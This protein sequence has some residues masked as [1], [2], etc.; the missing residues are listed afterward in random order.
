MRIVLSCLRVSHRCL[1]RRCWQPVVSRL[2]VWSLC[3]QIC[4]RL[5]LWA[6]L[7][8]RAQ[9]PCQPVCCRW[10]WVIPPVRPRCWQVRLLW[11]WRVWLWAAAAAGIAPNHRPRVAGRPV[12][13]CWF[14]R[15]LLWEFLFALVLRVVPHWRVWLLLP[16]WVRTAGSFWPGGRES[17]SNLNQ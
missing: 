16:W 6:Q 13:V 17:E 12:F 14:Q 2:R 7:V 8:D 1:A 4:Q 10:F 15:V 9:Q 11:R 3:L 5:C